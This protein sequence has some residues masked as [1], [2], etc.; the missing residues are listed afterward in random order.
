MPDIEL[1]QIQP[2]LVQAD[3]RFDFASVPPG[4]YR[5]IVTHRETGATG[6]GPT[7]LALNF[8]GGRGASP[9]PAPVAIAVRA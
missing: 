2:M 5:L 1:T 7:G 6:G 8:T 9:P 3:G 4:Q